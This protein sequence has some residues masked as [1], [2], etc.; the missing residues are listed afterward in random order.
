MCLDNDFFFFLGEISEKVVCIYGG[1][2]FV[3]VWHD[4]AYCKI[5][6]CVAFKG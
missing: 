3:C 5:A 2:S 4:M 6:L 1:K